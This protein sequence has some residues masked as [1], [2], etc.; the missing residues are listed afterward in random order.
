MPVAVTTAFLSVRS[1]RPA[2]NHVVAVTQRHLVGNDIGVL[3]HW[4]AF[5]GER[6][7][8]DLQGCRF[9]QPSVGRDGVAFLDQDDVAG[10]DLRGGDAASFSVA[11]DRSVRCGHRSQGRYRGL[12]S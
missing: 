4:Q 9:Q 11:N 6:G 1:C 12:G 10:D 3:G 2:E 8:S 5:A 7:L